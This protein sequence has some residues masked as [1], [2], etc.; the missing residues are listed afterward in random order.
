MPDP[1]LI[2]AAKKLREAGFLVVKPGWT[3]EM[4]ALGDEARLQS[5]RMPGELAACYIYGTLLAEA[6]AQASVELG[7]ILSE[8]MTLRDQVWDAL[9]PEAKLGSP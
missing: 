3:H 4:A 6:V 8:Q 5:R 2:A 1:D 7:E 9:P